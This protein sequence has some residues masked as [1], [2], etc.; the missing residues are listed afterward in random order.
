[1]FDKTSDI[2][3]ILVA[4]VLL[5]VIWRFY[6]FL[7]NRSR[8]VTVDEVRKKK[9]KA[10]TDD[11]SKESDENSIDNKN[12]DNENDL[13]RMAEPDLIKIPRARIIRQPFPVGEPALAFNN[14][15]FLTNE[16]IQFRYGNQLP[17]PNPPPPN[18]P[19]SPGYGPPET[20]VPSGYMAEDETIE[21]VFPE[22]TR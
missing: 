21:T 9:N 5:I 19:A 13:G 17:F 16:D 4:V 1:M 3:P 7:Q 20:P 10:N 6:V 2:A 18:G 14:P 12:K 15:S 8:I 11:V 22:F